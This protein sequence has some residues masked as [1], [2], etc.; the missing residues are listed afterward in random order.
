M[1]QKYIDIAL[2]SAALIS[3]GLII[4]CELKKKKTSNF[5]NTVG[6]DEASV[7]DRRGV[8]IIDGYHLCTE[9]TL[10]ELNMGKFDGLCD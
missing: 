6:V 1:K 4:R 3:V 5:R 10:R 8:D 7:S 9:G 2:C